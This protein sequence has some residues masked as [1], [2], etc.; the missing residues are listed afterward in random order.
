MKKGR[1][2]IPIEELDEETIE[3]MGLREHKDSYTAT[4]PLEAKH[5]ALGRVWQALSKLNQGDARWV[6]KEV[7]R[8]LTGRDETRGGYHPKK[9]NGVNK[10]LTKGGDQ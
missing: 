10:E 9:G 1:L 8:K 7:L 6:C 2:G 5:I 3:R 4:Q